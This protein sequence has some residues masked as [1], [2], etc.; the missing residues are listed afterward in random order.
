MGSEMCIRD[1]FLRAAKETEITGFL[2]TAWGDDGEECLFSHLEPLLLASMEIAEGNEKWEE[3]WMALT[4][5]SGEVLKARILFG[6]P[7]ISETVKHVVFRDFWFH[8]MSNE[9]RESLK[10]QWLKTLKETEDVELPNDL[11]FIRG[12]VDLGL[13]VINGEARVSD[14]IALSRIYAEL[15]LKERKPEGLE[16]IITRFWGAAGREDMDLR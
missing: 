9:N 2:I 16:R 13:K 3:K 12:L 6:N 1:S 7:E 8:R 15:W 4:G 5:E 14:Y 10:T 11:D